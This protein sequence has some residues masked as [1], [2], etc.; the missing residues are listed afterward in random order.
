MQNI[1][2]MAGKTHLTMKHKPRVLEYVE[3]NFNKIQSDDVGRDLY[4]L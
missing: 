4:R 1:G 2:L 3:S